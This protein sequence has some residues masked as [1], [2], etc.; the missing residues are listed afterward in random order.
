VTPSVAKTPP[1]C[2]TNSPQARIADSS[3]TNAVSFSSARTT[4]GELVYRPLQFHKRSQHFIGSHDELLSIAM[5]VN[6]PD[7]PPL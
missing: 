6:N 1:T 7:R 4:H 2:Q 5:R 3:S